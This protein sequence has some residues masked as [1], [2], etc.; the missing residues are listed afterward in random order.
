MTNQSAEDEKYFENGDV[1]SELQLSPPSSSSSSSVQKQAVDYTESYASRNEK[2]RLFWK[3]LGIRKQL[4]MIRFIVVWYAMWVFV[5]D[6]G[7]DVVSRI[8]RKV[9]FLD[10]KNVASIETSSSLDKAT[11]RY[12]VLLSYGLIITAIEKL[13]WIVDF[14]L[15]KKKNVDRFVET[16][17][18]IFVIIITAKLGL[19]DVRQQ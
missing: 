17:F 2:G 18:L 9:I 14:I 10:D 4:R 8:L 3:T 19:Y 12:L 5:T 11:E 6:T 7:D 1:K 16:C 13:K 15:E